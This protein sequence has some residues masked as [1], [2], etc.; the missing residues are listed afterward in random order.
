MQ[1][2]PYMLATF[3]KVWLSENHNIG[4]PKKLYLTLTHYFEAM[5]TIMLVIISFSVSPYIRNSFDTLFI[6]FH[7]LMNEWQ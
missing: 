3:I 2:P 6:C 5:T 4:C 1:S 7:D